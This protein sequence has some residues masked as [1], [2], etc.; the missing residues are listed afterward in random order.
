MI[1]REKRLSHLRLPRSVHVGL[2]R[3]CSLKLESLAIKPHPRIRRVSRNLALWRA[4]L[5]SR[6]VGQTAAGLRSPSAFMMVC[7]G[8]FDPTS[9]VRT[10]CQLRSRAVWQSMRDE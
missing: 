1:S 6:A 4:R 2:L 9:G 3:V 7:K 10:S 5:R 8:G